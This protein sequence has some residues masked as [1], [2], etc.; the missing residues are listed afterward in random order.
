MLGIL[1]L[2]Y[3]QSDRKAR[4]QSATSAS[5]NLEILIVEFEA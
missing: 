5:L 1:K 3:R 2:D 4:A